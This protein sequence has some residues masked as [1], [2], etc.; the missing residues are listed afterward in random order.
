MT[1]PAGWVKATVE[2]V[3]HVRLGRQR[4]PTHAKGDHLR[5]YLRAANV[6]W[7]GLD[8]SDV[9][10]MNFA[11]HEQSAYALR[12]GD[13]LLSE[14]SGSASEVGKP[15]FWNAELPECYFQNT[16]IRVRPPKGTE[17]FLFWQLRAAALNGQFVDQSRGVGIHHLGAERLSKF[18]VALAPSDEQRR[19]VAAIEEHLSRVGA[20]VDALERV[21]KE[22][23]RYRA[24][25]L[26]AACEGRLVPTEAALARAEGRSYEPASELLARILAERRAPWSGKKKYAEPA[27]P[28]TSSLPELPKGWVW[29][30]VDQLVSDGPTNGLYLPKSRYG[31]GTPILRIDDFQTWVSR[32]NAALQRVRASG[33]EVGAY[34]LRAGDLVINR[35][36]SPSHLGKS[37]VIE[38]RHLPALFESNMMRLA[39]AVGVSPSFIHLYL[40]SD[41]GRERLTKN[42]KWAV[43]QASIN[44]RDVGTTA[45][46]LPPLFEQHR[47]VTEVERRLSIADEVT[48]TVDAALARAARLRQSILNRAFEG[49]LVPQDPNDEPASVLLARIRTERESEAAD[50]PRHSR[51]V[52]RRAMTGS[53]TTS[54]K[55]RGRRRERDE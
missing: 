30:A 54:G 8:L 24:S 32:S 26:K 41:D 16:L 42:A 7:D 33:N 25:V 29:V 1:L 47:I 23:V 9:K 3:A 28:D 19:I 37:V 39:L 2:E 12:P 46:P 17:R 20:G 44:Q 11:P 45:V 48:A 43:N 27:Q 31:E 22:L 50:R 6:T 14:A 21:K 53:D 49:R 52:R 55:A 18:P 13:L 4:S 38:Q 51:G 40:A 5:P 34:A 36:N 10:S 15:A 35:V